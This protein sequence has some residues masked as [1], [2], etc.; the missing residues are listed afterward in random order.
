MPWRPI[1][2]STQDAQQLLKSLVQT[3]RFLVDRNLGPQFVPALRRLGYNATDVFAPKII[4]QSN[5]DVLAA[6]SSGRRILLTQDRNFLD[7][8]RFPP[9]INV[10]IVVLPVHAH[11]T[12]MN[13]VV[14]ALSILRKE[15]D[16]GRGTKISVGEDGRL[17]VTM[18]DQD[19][20]ARKST[21]YKLRMGGPPLIWRSAEKAGHLE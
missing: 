3:C 13:A 15:R 11:H 10:G 6:A 8:Y 2:I 16:L 5:E 1:D 4:T 20:G 18:R 21:H 9:N 7:D 12:L 17:T 14:Y 19:S